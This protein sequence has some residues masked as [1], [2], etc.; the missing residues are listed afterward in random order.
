VRIHQ[1]GILII[2]NNELNNGNIIIKIASLLSYGNGSS[3]T[4]QEGA[5]IKYGGYIP[6]IIIKGNINNVIE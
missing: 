4:I 1:L 2:S 5:S 6:F 3:M